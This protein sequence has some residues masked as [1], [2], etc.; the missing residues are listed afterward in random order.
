MYK[1]LLLFIIIFIPSCSISAIQPTNRFEGFTDEELLSKSIEMAVLELTNEIAS[2]TSSIN[3]IKLISLN[4]QK[5]NDYI[6]QYLQQTFQ[7]KHISIN[8]S[9]SSDLTIFIT[10]IGTS[11][12]V[13][14]LGT[15]EIPIPFSVTSFPEVNIYK[16]KK[17]SAG[18][19]IQYF[20]AD[21][22]NK[23]IAL[24]NINNHTVFIFNL[25]LENSNK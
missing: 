17:F 20:F 19:I 9:S 6:T 25:H 21:K 18:L 2:Q 14:S 16:N 15:P 7:L 8:D 1:L 24:N 10:A 12:D 5:F 23:I 11:S 22:T 3:N 13:Y 4:S